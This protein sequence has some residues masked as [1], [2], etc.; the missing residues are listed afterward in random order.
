MNETPAPLTLDDVLADARMRLGRG[1]ADRHHALHTPVV[2][3]ADADARIMV[4]RAVDPALAG[5]RFH[6]DTRAPKCAVIA[7]DPR[8]TVLGYDPGRRIQV[9]LGGHARIETSGPLADAAW[10]AAAASSRRCYLAEAGPGAALD[11]PGS[12]LPEALRT[13]S[14]ALDETAPGRAH[15]AVLVFRAETLDWLRLGHDGGVRA[16]FAR[17]AGG[18]WRGR[19]VAP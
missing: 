11:A 19:W 13:R 1:A 8:L 2:V 12:A 9:R 18:E 17:D 14:P 6:T 7:A 16:R 4:L 15:F 10:A 3:T 5:L